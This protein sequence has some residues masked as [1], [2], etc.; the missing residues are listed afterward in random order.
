MKKYRLRILIILISGSIFCPLAAQTVEQLKKERKQ[1]QKNLELTDKKLQATKKN[2]KKSLNKIN[3]LNQNLIERKALIKNYNSEIGLLDNKIEKITSDIKNLEKDLDK[4]KQNYTRLIQK[5]QANKNVYSK[6]M[7]VLSA[8]SFDQSMRR[9]RY[10]H[11]FTSYQKQQG[12][13]IKDI[14]KTLVLK[15]DS[16]GEH[17][18][19]KIV[20]VQAKEQEAQK[21]KNDQQKEKIILSGLQKEEE[22]LTAE[23]RKQR[24]KVN[25]IN[26]KIERII[27]EEIRKAEEK[28]RAEEAKRLAEAKKKA[29]AEKNRKKAETAKENTSGKSK[30]TTGGEIKERTETREKEY[31]ASSL[32][33]SKET[34]EESLLSGNFE[35]NRGRLPWPTE[36]GAISGHFGVQPH[37]VLRQV[38]INNKGT[39][40]QSPSGTNARSVYDG[41]VT[42]VFSIPGGGNAVIVQSGDYRCVYSGL[43][44]VFVHSGDKVRSKQSVGKIYTDEENGK[45]ELYF[46]IY[47]GRTVINPESW[48]SR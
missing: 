10:L 18:R 22:K 37:P 26:E 47:K 19:G 13:K 15:T 33:V 27:A 21:L 48:I 43:A 20:A 24:I 30:E 38:T 36:R 45:T 34:R 23:Y 39:Y 16:L 40:F 8:E 42:A 6:I 1:I 44:S 14:Q 5:A 32:D 29:E 35:R 2:E 31:V 3:I 17:K 46:Q 9:M 28:K 25:E 11:E 41:V 7:F 12:D 4:L